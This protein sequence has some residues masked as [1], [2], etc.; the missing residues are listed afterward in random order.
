[1]IEWLI[2]GQ[3]QTGRKNT[4]ISWKYPL[5]VPYPWWKRKLCIQTWGLKAAL[6]VMVA[7]PVCS[8]SFTC[9][10]RASTPGASWFILYFKELVLI[11]TDSHSYL[12][13]N[14]AYISA[15]SHVWLLKIPSQTGFSIESSL[16]IICRF[17]DYF[18]PMTTWIKWSKRLFLLETINQ[19][20]FVTVGSSFCGRLVIVFVMSCFF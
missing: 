19:A 2:H 7:P 11:L 16:Q 9:G 17:S 14:H 15:A 1:M 13:K 18:F 10:E 12:Q 5:S 3:G 20:C 4:V 8:Q 6:P